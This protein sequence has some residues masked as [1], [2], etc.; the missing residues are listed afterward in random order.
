[1]LNVPTATLAAKYVI[2]THYLMKVLEF[3]PE[4]Q[5]VDLI[6]DVYEYTNAPLGDC[7]INNE[8]GNKVTAT[9]C[10]LD[11]IPNV[12]VKQERWGQFEIQC[13][14]KE[15]DVGYIEVFTND[16]RDW[17]ENGGASIPWS[18]SHFM[19]T[20]CVFVPFVPNKTTAVSDY[21]QD[22]TKLVIKSQNTAIIIEDQNSDTNSISMTAKEVSLTGDTKIDGNLEVT[23][24]LTVTKSITAQEDIKSETGDVIAGTVSLKGHTHQA[25]GLAAPNGPVTGVTGQPIG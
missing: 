11:I 9:L 24:D 23:G 13:C 18:D 22:N 21:P 2:K 16:I 8:F 10:K 3:H 19:K 20:S 7:V 4:T 5:T 6:Q 17:V 1:M 25:G 12:P 15:G 14:P